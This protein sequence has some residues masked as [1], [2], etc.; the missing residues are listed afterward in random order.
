MI[1]LK[2]MISTKPK[3]ALRKKLPDGG[4]KGKL[5]EYEQDLILWIL[6]VRRGGYAFSIDAIIAYLYKKNENLRLIPYVIMNKRVSNIIKKY[7][8]V[9]RKVSHIGQ[10]IPEKGKDLIYIFLYEIINK[11]RYLLINDNELFRIVNCDETAVYYE[12]PDIYTIDIKGHKEIIINT[13]GN[14]SKKISVL[15]SIA[16][17]GNRLPPFLI[18]KG[19]EEKTLE[20]NLNK[21]INIL[22]KK[23]FAVCQKKAWCDTN[24]FKKWYEKFFLN[25]EKKIIKK[26]C[27]LVLDKSPAHCN[28]EIIKEFEKNNTYYTFIPGG[29]TR[30]LQPLYL[31][32]NMPFKKALKKNIYYQKQIF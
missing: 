19:A 25:Y 14:E 23:I 20:K 15:L 5:L 8:L 6:E 11:R 17:N 12:N 10:S 9:I 4:R 13:D 31:G 7:N 2:I 3:N 26:P 18:F 16:A 24:I 32:I 21:N 29:L 30:Y 28:N 1:H 22:N 27:L